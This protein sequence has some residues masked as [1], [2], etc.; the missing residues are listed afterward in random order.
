MN[1]TISRQNE[2][3]QETL[4]W[5]EEE[6][7]RHGLVDGYKAKFI[8]EE[9]QW[10][11]FAVKPGNLNDALERAEVLVE[12]EEAWQERLPPSEWR[13]MLIPA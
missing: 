8:R 9:N 10:R 7:K 12:L 4:T 13:L 11:F 6:A 5:L 2:T 3:I 1:T